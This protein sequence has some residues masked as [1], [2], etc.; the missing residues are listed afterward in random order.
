MTPENWQNS[1]KYARNEDKYSTYAKQRSVSNYYCYIIF[2]PGR[3]S[4][5][6]K[7]Y[8]KNVKL[9]LILILI[10]ILKL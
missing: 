1:L 2:N 7:N 5:D 6:F 3:K 8:K 10:L 4:R 9:L